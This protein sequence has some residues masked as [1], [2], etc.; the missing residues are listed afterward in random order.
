MSEAKILFGFFLGL[1]SSS[2]GV[3][4]A[5]LFTVSRDRKKEFSKTSLKFIKSFHETIVNLDNADIQVDRLVRDVF[6]G[7]KFAMMEF[8][9]YLRGKK[10]KSFQGAWSQYEDYCNKH[11]YP[12]S[13]VTSFFDSTKTE[14]ESDARKEMKHLLNDLLSF[15]K[16]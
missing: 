8:Q 15:T 7:H 4:L 1:L 6:W 12:D 16:V 13:V 5:N 3:W 2:F 14:S 10:L 11:T 9:I